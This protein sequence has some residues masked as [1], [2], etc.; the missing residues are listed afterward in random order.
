MRARQTHGKLVDL[1]NNVICD[2]SLVMLPQN[3]GQKK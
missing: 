3:K 2:E 1:L